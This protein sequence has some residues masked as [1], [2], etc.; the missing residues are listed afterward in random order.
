M[1]EFSAEPGTVY[2]RTEDGLARAPQAWIGQ[3]DYVEGPRA[4]FSGGAGLLSTARDYARFLQMLLGGGALDGVR[5]LSAASVR[6]MTTNQVGDLHQDGRFGFGL[7]FELVDDVARADRPASPGEFGW[8]GAYFTRYWVAPHHD[9]VA[10]FLAQL[11]PT[12]GTPVQDRF[13]RLVY[14]AVAQGQ[15][16]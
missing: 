9:L 6:E 3:G 4:S 12:G 13:R 14:E 2:S 16:Q 7:G 5:L 10:V 11:L 1:L 15:A 8:A